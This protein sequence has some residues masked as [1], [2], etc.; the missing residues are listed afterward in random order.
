MMIRSEI[1]GKMKV[2][3]KQLFSLQSVKLNYEIKKQNK[4]KKPKNFRVDK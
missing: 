1:K 2:I 4:K 3:A